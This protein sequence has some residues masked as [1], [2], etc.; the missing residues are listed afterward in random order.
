LLTCVEVPEGL[1]ETERLA[2]LLAL[3]ETLALELEVCRAVPKKRE[4]AAAGYSSE[5]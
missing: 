4:A 2:V 3:P 1:L 5:G